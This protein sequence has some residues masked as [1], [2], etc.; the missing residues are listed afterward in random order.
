[1]AKNTDN[2]KSFKTYEINVNRRAFTKERFREV[3]L[4]A[5]FH[6]LKLEFNGHAFAEIEAE[7][8]RYYIPY[9]FTLNETVAIVMQHGMK[10]LYLELD[11]NRYIEINFD[12]IIIHGT[13]K[14]YN[15]CKDMLPFAEQYLIPPTIFQFDFTNNAEWLWQ[16]YL[17]TQFENC[18]KIG[19]QLFGN[20]Y[21]MV[22]PFEDDEDEVIT[23]QDYQKYKGKIEYVVIRSN[24]QD[25]KILFIDNTTK[26][27]LGTGFDELE[28]LELAEILRGDDF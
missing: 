21:I 19:N 25:D 9:S 11:E 7:N 16:K 6:Y 4:T 27:V 24:I 17:N 22:H 14:L 12:T 10:M 15:K 2:S 18:M 23:Y 13:E 3:Q 28:R 1:M 26:E 8:K 5:Y 20:G